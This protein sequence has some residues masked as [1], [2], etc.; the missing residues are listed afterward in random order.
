MSRFFVPLLLMACK[1]ADEKPHLNF[2]DSRVLE[3]CD[4]Q[5]DAAFQIGDLS[6]DGDTLI[7]GVSY[8]GGCEA[9][10]WQI[11]WDGTTQDIV[12]PEVSLHIGHNNNGDSCEA[13]RT[14]TIEFDI[15][16][17]Q[18]PNPNVESLTVYV[19]GQALSYAY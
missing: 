2:N 11:C 16:P 4:V 17:L 13:I 18:V 15:S 12:P 19:G 5:D 1:P 9:H 7:I 14:E 8:S 6:I 3:M 10:E